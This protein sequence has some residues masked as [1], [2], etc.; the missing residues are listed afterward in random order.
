M[1][2]ARITIAECT[3]ESAR[4]AGMRHRQ[5]QIHDL[6]VASIAKGLP[7]GSGIDNSV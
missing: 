2:E 5:G 6:K 4:E 3:Q 7:Y 1:E